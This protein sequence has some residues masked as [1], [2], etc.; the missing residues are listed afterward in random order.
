MRAQAARHTRRHTGADA[1]LHAVA[2]ALGVGGDLGVDL[3]AAAGLAVAEEARA[4]DGGVACKLGYIQVSRT[5]R[6][7]AKAALKV[8]GGVALGDH[9]GVH[10]GGVGAGREEG[11]R[12]RCRDHCALG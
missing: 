3:A 7:A 1:Y 11:E 5:V 9:R 6:H 12:C 8:R 4:A 2:R 10:G